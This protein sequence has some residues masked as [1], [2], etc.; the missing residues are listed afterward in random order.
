MLDKTAEEIM[1]IGGAELFKQALPRVDRLYIT[2]V[3]QE[4]SGD[5]WFPTIDFAEWKETQCETGEAGLRFV[6]LE[7][8]V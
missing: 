7:R 5:C 4:I 1:V 8:L 3:L 6:T 2:W